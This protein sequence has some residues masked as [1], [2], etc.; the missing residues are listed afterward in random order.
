[1]QDLIIDKRIGA[2]GFP[3]GRV[4]SAAAVAGLLDLTFAAALWYPMGVAPT[5]IFQSI[6]SGL[7]GPSAFAG[8]W[9]T[10]LIGIGLHFLIMAVIASIYAALVPPRLKPRPLLTGALYG[11]A[12]WLGMNLI[13][14]PLSAAP[15]TLP[16]FWMG[17]ADLAGHIAFVGIPIAWL[18]GRPRR[19]AAPA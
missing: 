15:L 11:L 8:G 12:I 16:P 6:A 18:I 3:I 4:I 7:L 10:A 14:V 1:M 17:A 2:A 9:R 19:D 5:T 13:V